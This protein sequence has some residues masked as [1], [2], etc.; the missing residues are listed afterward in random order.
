MMTP[1]T[2]K[3]RNGRHKRTFT[4]QARRSCFVFSGEHVHLTNCPHV[5]THLMSEIMTS[6]YS[7]MA[8]LALETFG[9]TCFMSHPCTMSPY[10]IAKN[11]STGELEHKSP[12]A[13]FNCTIAPTRSFVLQMTCFIDLEQNE[14]PPHKQRE[15]VQSCMKDHTMKEHTTSQ[16]RGRCYSSPQ[17]EPHLCGQQQQ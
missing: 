13:V 5:C 9:F 7:T 15:A 11:A 10:C 14:N 2:L 1:S 3:A 16:Q 17:L 4:H 6:L 8:A 12:L